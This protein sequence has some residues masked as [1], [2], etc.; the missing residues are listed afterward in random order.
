MVNKCYLILKAVLDYKSKEEI[1]G[2]QREGEGEKDIGKG[3]L[4]GPESESWV[5]V[6]QREGEGQKNSERAY[7]NYLL[8]NQL[9]IWEM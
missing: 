3:K 9:R 1:N 4:E 6:G 5:G 2:S 8:N 7:L